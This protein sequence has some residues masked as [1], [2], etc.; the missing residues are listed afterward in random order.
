MNNDTNDEFTLSLTRKEMVTLE[1]ALRVF[2]N[3]DAFTSE[4]QEGADNLV[5]YI[6]RVMGK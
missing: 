6:R 1:M 3:T 5:R 2:C 4:A